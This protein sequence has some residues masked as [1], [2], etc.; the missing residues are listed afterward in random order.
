MYFRSEQKSKRVIA[1]GGQGSQGQRRDVQIQTEKRQK[2]SCGDGWKLEGWYELMISKICISM[3]TCTGMYVYT[4]MCM[5][6]Y[7]HVY[8]L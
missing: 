1:I 5:Y 2:E 4:Y 3:F 8:I 7:M 6:V